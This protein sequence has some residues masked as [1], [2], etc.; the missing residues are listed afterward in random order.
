MFQQTGGRRNE[1]TTEIEGGN[2]DEG[3][4]GK[5][6]MTKRGEDYCGGIGGHLRKQAK[7]DKG[8]WWRQRELE[9]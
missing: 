5:K 9:D 8:G 7:R 3:E 4:R 6:K 1:R 2:K